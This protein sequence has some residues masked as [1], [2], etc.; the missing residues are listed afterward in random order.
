MRGNWFYY[1][2][3][4]Y[5]NVEDNG[6]KWKWEF[7]TNGS[8]NGIIFFKGSVDRRKDRALTIGSGSKRAR[9][10]CLHWWW[11][12]FYIFVSIPMEHTHTQIILHQAGPV[13][14]WSAINHCQKWIQWILIE[15]S[16]E[17]SILTFLFCF[18]IVKWTKRNRNISHYKCN[19]KCIFTNKYAQ[20]IIIFSLISFTND[21]LLF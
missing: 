17:S 1:G 18:F 6:G 19:L 5:Y 11:N 8:G 21:P 7:N 16:E 20:I 9:V 10:C 2:Y 3:Y 14:H 13:C 4:Y 15:D 12:D